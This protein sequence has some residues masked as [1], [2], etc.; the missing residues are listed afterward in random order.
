VPG[1]GDGELREWGS[2]GPGAG[3]RGEAASPPAAN[4]DW[5][6]YPAARHDGSMSAP[7]GCLAEQRHDDYPGTAGA[8]FGDG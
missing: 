2:G 7:D 5:D 4:T 1:G 6:R 8:E 3:P